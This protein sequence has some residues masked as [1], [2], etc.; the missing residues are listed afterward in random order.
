MPGV[1]LPIAPPEKLLEVQPDYVL[2]VAWN[3][4]DE[5]IRQQAEYLERGGR[6]IVPVPSPEIL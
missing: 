2:L 4:R 1:H 5:V 6:F 3:Y